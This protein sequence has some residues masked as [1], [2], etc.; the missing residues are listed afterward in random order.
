MTADELRT[1]L[2]MALRLARADKN[3]AELEQEILDGFSS[4]LGLSDDERAAI[5][6]ENIQP[7]DAVARLSN[8]EAREFLM[9]SLC[10]VAF[11]DGL[12][13]DSEIELIAQTHELVG[14]SV[15]L[16]PWEE[17]ESYV[18]EVIDTLLQFSPGG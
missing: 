16:K 6:D 4:A 12:R 15:S 3:V 17:W 2:G 1:I 5:A 9:K 7:A 13:H 10:A 8:G 11:A 14:G 18:E